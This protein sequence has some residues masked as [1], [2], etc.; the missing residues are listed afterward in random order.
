M[1]RDDS[2]RLLHGILDLWAGQTL[3]FQKLD[4]LG[5]RRCLRLQGKR[6][7]KRNET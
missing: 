2:G 5:Q 1:G 6:S 7:A 3:G 4:A